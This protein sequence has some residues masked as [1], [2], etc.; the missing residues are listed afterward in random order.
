MKRIL[1]IVGWGMAMI[2]V[3]FVVSERSRAVIIMLMILA[4]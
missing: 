2:S 4:I 1:R 3:L